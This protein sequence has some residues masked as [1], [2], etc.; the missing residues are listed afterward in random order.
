MTQNPA[1]TCST[2]GLPQLPLDLVRGG[3]VA[4]L[5]LPP[6]PRSQPELR[7]GSCGGPT[8]P[9]SC[10]WELPQQ[11]NGGWRWSGGE[12]GDCEKYR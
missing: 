7:E 1:L 12:V 10:S 3:Q 8:S 2:P 6:F 9:G 4:T 5:E 11:R